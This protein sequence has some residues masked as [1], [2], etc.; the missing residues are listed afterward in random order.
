MKLTKSQIAGWV[1]SFLI[2][3]FLI[4][5]SAR[6]K[7][8]QWEGKAEMF[9]KMGWSEATLFW[10]GVVEVA[11]ALLFLIPRTGFLGAVLLTAYLGGATATHVRIEDQ[12]FTTVIMGVLVWIALGLRRP[13][14]FSLA[15]G[16]SR[17]AVAGTDK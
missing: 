10:V 17:P 6:G 9:A 4:V 2:A 8:T 14:V 16:M 5:L 7:F 15:L 12:F 11:I 13:E 1:L 3:V